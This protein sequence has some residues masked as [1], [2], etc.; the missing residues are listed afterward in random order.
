MSFNNLRKNGPS[1]F[2]EIMLSQTNIRNMIFD[3]RSHDLH[4]FRGGGATPCVCAIFKEK[5]RHPFF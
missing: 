2:L 1:L 5:N 4:F 3:R